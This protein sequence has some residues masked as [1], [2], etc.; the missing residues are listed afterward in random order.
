MVLRDLYHLMDQWDQ[1]LLEARLAQHRLEAL[2]GQGHPV[3]LLGQGRRHRWVQQVLEVL[4]L[5][6]VLQ[7]LKDLQ[8]RYHLLVLVVQLH[9]VVLVVLGGRL[10][11][12]LVQGHL[13]VL[14]GQSGQ[15]RLPVLAVLRGQSGQDLLVDLVVLRRLRGQ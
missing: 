14:R 1:H 15:Y 5:Q 13:E 2:V 6:L 10:R 7:D 11:G 8:G 9:L 12:R 3:V 4:L